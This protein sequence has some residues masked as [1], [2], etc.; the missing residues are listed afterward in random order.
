MRLSESTKRVLRTAYAVVAT[1]AIAVPLLLTEVPTDVPGYQLLAGFAGAVV[2]V[3]H[4][5]TR[6]EDR[7]MLPA[8]LRDVTPRL[9]VVD[10][11]ASAAADAAAVAP[12][13]AEILPA[14]LAQAVESAAPAVADVAGQ[15]LAATPADT[16]AD[17]AP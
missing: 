15:L 9:D 16:H 12:T 8:F 2:A 17:A 13:V 5:I 6:L 10:A 1:L 7:G 11:I 14:Q 4:V 3:N